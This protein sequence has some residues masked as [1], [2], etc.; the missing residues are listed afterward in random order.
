LK[1]RRS[2]QKIASGK[3]TDMVKVYTNIIN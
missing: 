1:I 3:G 2:G